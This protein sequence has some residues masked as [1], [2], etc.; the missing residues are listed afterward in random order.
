MCYSG[1]DLLTIAF[2]VAVL[3][4]LTLDT[5]IGQIIGACHSRETPSTTGKEAV[6]L[7]MS[8]D[9]VSP[10]PTHCLTL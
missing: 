6:F 9:G 10:L 4:R 2:S 5:G 7:V 1:C 8:A 3:L